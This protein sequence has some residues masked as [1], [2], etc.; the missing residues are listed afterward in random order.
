[1]NKGR[2]CQSALRHSLQTGAGQI[3]V[4]RSTAP[5]LSL[6][7]IPILILNLVGISRRRSFR[8]GNVTAGAVT[9]TLIRPFASGQQPQQQSTHNDHLSSLH[10]FLRP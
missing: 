4:E 1:M 9:G 10:H 6:L 3:V 5:V 8:H 2:H 7:L